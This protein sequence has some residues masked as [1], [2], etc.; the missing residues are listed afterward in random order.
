MGSARE[1]ARAGR[2]A[3]AF[4]AILGALP[5]WRPLSPLH[6]APIGLTWDRDLGR[7]MTREHREQLLTT[8]RGFR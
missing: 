7:I 4:E 1:L 2:D 8:A 3:E 6:L 5:S